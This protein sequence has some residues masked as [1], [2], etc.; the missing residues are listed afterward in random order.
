MNTC[1]HCQSLEQQQRQPRVSNHLPLPGKIDEVNRPKHDCKPWFSVSALG[2]FNA[3]CCG[4]WNTSAALLMVFGRSVTLWGLSRDHRHPR[5]SDLM[6]FRLWWNWSNINRNKTCPCFALST[7]WDLMPFTMWFRL[8]KSPFPPQTH[9]ASSSTGFVGGW[10]NFSHF[11]FHWIPINARHTH[12]WKSGPRHRPLQHSQSC[13]RSTGALA[14][15]VLRH[16]AEPHLLS[17]L[18]LSQGQSR[19]AVN[20]DTL[21]WTP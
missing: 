17:L 3:N 7:Q 13:C 10:W 9:M 4:T 2:A 5:A 19:K 16:E 12:T 6:N 11:A 18:F 1:G 20:K 14:L 8:L 21:H 15:G